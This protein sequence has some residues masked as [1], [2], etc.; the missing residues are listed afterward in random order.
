[1]DYRTYPQAVLQLP[2]S[3]IEITREQYIFYGKQ[4]KVKDGVSYRPNQIVKSFSLNNRS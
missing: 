2:T 4:N 1:M 3:T